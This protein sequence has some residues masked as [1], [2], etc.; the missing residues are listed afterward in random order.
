MISFSL[1]LGQFIIFNFKFL[2]HNLIFLLIFLAVLFDLTSYRLF[3][4]YSTPMAKASRV[5]E[6]QL[7]WT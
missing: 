2:I 5:A 1:D 7:I 6:Y 3:F 4:V